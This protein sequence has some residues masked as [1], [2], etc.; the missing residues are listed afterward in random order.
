MFEQLKNLGNMMQQAQQ[1]Q[2]RMAEAKEK[3]A[4]LRVQGTAGGG[5]VTVEASGDMKVIS[6]TLEQSLV[7]TQDREMMEELVTS[8]VNQA[9]QKAKE[10]AAQAM[11][12]VAG[13]MNIPGLGDALSKLGLG[14]H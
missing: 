7:E 4:E 11:A 5:M 12:E 10:G 9:L 8:A 1:M 6:V 3:I 13:G 14:G 2:S